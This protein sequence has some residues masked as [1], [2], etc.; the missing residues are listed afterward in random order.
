MAFVQPGRL[1]TSAVAVIPSIDSF[2]TPRAPSC[3]NLS[4]EPPWQLVG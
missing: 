2:S 3:P 1:S 4:R